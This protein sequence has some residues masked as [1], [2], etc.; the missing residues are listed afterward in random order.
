[1]SSAT[2]TVSEVNQGAVQ[3]FS[4]R[5]V[6]MLNNAA[7]MLMT[8][9]G[10]RTRL[11]DVMAG[12]PPSTSSQIAAAAELNERYVREW[13]GAMVTGRFVDFDPL[14]QTYSLPAAHAAVLTRAASPGNLA[15]EAQFISVLGSVETEIV[16]CFQKGGGV[17]YSSFERFHEV[18]AEESS[19]TVVWAL[20]DN[21]LP[22]VDGLGERLETGIEVL[23]VGCGSGLALMRMAEAFPS[24]RFTGFDLCQEAIDRARGD[25]AA[26][27]LTNVC[28]EQRDVTQLGL[29]DRFDLITGFDVI[30]DQ[31]HPDRVLAGIRD[32]LK[33]G[34][35][36]L[37]QDIDAHTDLQD[38][39]EHP[40]GPFL[41]T[42]SCMHCMTVS[43]AQEGAG[44]GTCWGCEQA[45]A[46]LAEAGFRNITTQRLEHDEL[47]CYYIMSK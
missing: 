21:I 39:R 1:M 26:R 31:A 15:V 3:V 23:D 46:M 10:H 6:E 27:G 45:E 40:L 37:M 30:H 18:M 42:I 36:F 47:N 43:L 20:L 34:G 5:L 7:M 38:N 9:V 44:L 4:E 35:T 25:S 17:P 13:L 16:E 12:L 32:A 24:S 14:E 33:P 22:L 2:E 28:F 11:F 41:Y 8:S 29:T 19:Q